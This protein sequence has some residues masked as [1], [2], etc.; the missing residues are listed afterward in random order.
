VWDGFFLKGE[1]FILR[2]VIALL[3]LLQPILLK[4]H[5][6]EVVRALREPASLGV[7]V[8]QA[9]AQGGGQA[10]AAQAQEDAD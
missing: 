4:M 8:V 1:V 3:Q 9:A 5:V 6:S 2:T 7:F 10:A